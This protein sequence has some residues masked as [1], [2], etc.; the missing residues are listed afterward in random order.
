M[1]YLSKPKSYVDNLKKSENTLG[2]IGELE[3]L[4]TL[5]DLKS[6]GQ[7]IGCAHIAR[8]EF[9]ERFS[10]QIKQ[11][12][13]VY[14]ED[15]VVEEDGT[16]FWSGPKRFPHPKEFNPE[17]E[18]HLLFVV[19]MA[20]LIAKSLG[21]E[22]NTNTEEVREMM[23][24]VEVPEFLPK[25]GMKIKVKDED[26]D[27]ADEYVEKP[28]D[29]VKLTNLITTFHPSNLQVTKSDFSRLE[30]EKDD[31]SN[32]HIDFIHSCSQIRATNYELPVCSR[33]ETKMIAG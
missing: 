30:F 31:D 2:L 19:A 9:E 26:P 18:T 13:H 25:E 1:D 21:I 17:D 23:S 32:H 20:N 22:G 24:N 14:S 15:Y 6:D 27:E 16:L 7:F 5:T 3:K 4:K 29:L 11:L 8:L 28:E 33:H 12:T 10:N